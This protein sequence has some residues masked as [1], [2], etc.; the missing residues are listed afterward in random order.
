MARQITISRVELGMAPLE[1]Q[2]PDNGFYVSDEWKTG[3]TQWQRY[4]AAGSAWVEGERII[5]QRRISVDEIFTIYI[6]AGSAASMKTKENLV[7]QA[8]SQYRYDF[9][10]SWDGADYNFTG[11]GAADI[12]RADDKVDPIMLKNGWSALEIT[13]PRDPGNG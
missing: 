3:A 2:D 10:I 1:L 12:R 5:G 11:N 13:I 6:H 4:N 7:H 9:T 8:L